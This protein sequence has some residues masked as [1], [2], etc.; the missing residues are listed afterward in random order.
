MDENLIKFKILAS[1]VTS[2]T[3]DMRVA[4]GKALTI[5]DIDQIV[6]SYK[7]GWS[8]LDGKFARVVARCLSQI[9]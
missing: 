4:V 6:S 3:L 5:K 9:E 8:G 1:K 7:D 2:G